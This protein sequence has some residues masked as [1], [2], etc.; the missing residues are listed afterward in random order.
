[1][2]AHPIFCL[3][4]RVMRPLILVYARSSL[5]CSCSSQFLLSHPR[6]ATA[7]PEFHMLIHVLQPLILVYACSSASCSRSSQVSSAHPRRVAAHNSGPTLI[8]MENLFIFPKI[9]SFLS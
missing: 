7:H 4:I 9:H 2:G 5:S 8:A 3:L 6:R 1:V